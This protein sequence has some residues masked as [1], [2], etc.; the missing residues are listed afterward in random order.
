MR[1]LTWAPIQT[2]EEVASDPQAEAL[3]VL[4]L[5]EDHPGGPFHTV[6]APFS[7]RGADVGVRGPAPGLGQHSR[8]ILAEAGIAPA[9]IDRLVDDGVV[10]DGATNDDT[11]TT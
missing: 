6:N 11:S 8:A 1:G 9:A 5:M 2:V 3:G 7:I 4:H 10:T